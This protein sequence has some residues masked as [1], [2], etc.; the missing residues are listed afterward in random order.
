MI[1]EFK[2]SN[3]KQQSTHKRVEYNPPDMEYGKGS[4]NDVR[5]E[6]R[7]NYGW[8]SPYEFY[9]AGSD[10][11][12]DTQSPTITSFDYIERLGKDIEDQIVEADKS[13]VPNYFWCETLS[14]WCCFKPT[15]LVPTFEHTHEWA[16]QWFRAIAAIATMGG[17]EILEEIS[18]NGLHWDMLWKAPVYIFTS[19]ASAIWAIGDEIVSAISGGDTIQDKYHAISLPFMIYNWATAAS[20]MK[21]AD[22]EAENIVEMKSDPEHYT[23]ILM[24]RMCMSLYMWNGYRRAWIP[25]KSLVDVFSKFARSHSSGMV[26]HFIK[27]EFVQKMLKSGTEW[28]TGTDKEEAINEWLAANAL[29]EEGIEAFRV[30]CDNYANDDDPSNEG[31]LIFELGNISLNDRLFD[32]GNIEAA[33]MSIIQNYSLDCN[34]FEPLV[35]RTP[36]SKLQYNGIDNLDDEH[37]ARWH[38][39]EQWGFWIPLQKD[40]CKIKLFANDTFQLLNRPYSYLR[41]DKRDHWGW[42]HK[43]LGHPCFFRG[44]DNELWLAY[45]LRWTSAN[46]T[47]DKSGWMWSETTKMTGEYD[48]SK[49]DIQLWDD[50]INSMFEKHDDYGFD[51]WLMNGEYGL[52]Y[53]KFTVSEEVPNEILTADDSTLNPN[54][55]PLIN[56]ISKLDENTLTLSLSTGTVI[57]RDDDNSM[58]DTAERWK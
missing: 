39:I 24:P 47:E 27:S 52:E 58:L 48:I 43:N 29:S 53:K 18:K 42:I 3:S 30:A 41:Y 8:M 26:Q 13:D 31:K 55:A 54:S 37:W 56:A 12:V 49:D 15:A 25:V 5:E 17:T 22:V 6:Q 16:P 2:Y 10:T 11:G 36:L 19:Y 33:N 46:G 44:N 9:Y 45:W 4:F 7:K 23:E 50:I 38:F 20:K 40:K 51:E 21:D 35:G 32:I 34:S 28:K 57:S 1:D 14:N